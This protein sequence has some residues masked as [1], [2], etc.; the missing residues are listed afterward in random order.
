MYIDKDEIIRSWKFIL[1][2]I[3]IYEFRYV[4]ILIVSFVGFFLVLF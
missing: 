1:I 3:N 2:Y 4:D